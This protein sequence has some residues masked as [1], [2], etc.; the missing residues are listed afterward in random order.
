MD[1]SVPDLR[2]VLAALFTGT[3]NL[4]QFQRWVGV[5]SLAIELYGSDEQLELLNLV[6]GLL[7]EYTSDSIDATELLDD[8]RTESLVQTKLADGLA[9]VPEPMSRHDRRSARLDAMKIV[10]YGRVVLTSRAN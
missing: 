8:L 2:G 10:S 9:T 4:V 3:V 6:A 5:N 1:D 7:D